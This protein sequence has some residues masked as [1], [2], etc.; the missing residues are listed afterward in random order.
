MLYFSPMKPSRLKGFLERTYRR[1]HRP[2]FL[3]LDPLVCIRPFV[4]K[5]DIEVAGL[6]AAA[7]SYGRVETIVASVNAIFSKTGTNISSFAR[8]S[9]FMEKRR[10]FASFRHRFTGGASLALLLEGIGRALGEYGTLENLFVSSAGFQS[11]IQREALAGFST[12][13]IALAPAGRQDSP[14]F[15]YL[16]PDARAGSACKR[17]NLYLRWM[18]RKKDGVDLGIWSKVSPSRLI[19]PVDTHVARIARRFGLTS[20]NAADWRM[21]EEITAALRT[22]DP[23]DP[24]RFDF[25]LCRSGMIGHRTQDP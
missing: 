13:L 1:Y 15:R 6:V 8:V 19:I 18:V 2:E 24:L 25:S 21:A 3:G 17:L 5:D 12:A 10:M 16:L 9:S 14:G 11:G 23:S 20:R 22:V 4:G 7:L